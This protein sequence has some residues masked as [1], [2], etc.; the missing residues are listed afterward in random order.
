MIKKIKSSLFIKVFLLTTTLLIVVSLLVFGI[1]AVVTPN[2]YSAALND[3]LDVKVNAFTSEL[4]KVTLDTSKNLFEQFVRGTEIVNVEL[5]DANGVLVTSP[6]AQGGATEN[7]DFLA[8][9]TGV[10]IAS[11]NGDSPLVSNSYYFSFAGSSDRYLLVVYTSA[12]QVSQL[13]QT[14]LQIF[15]FLLLA[16][17]LISFAMSSIFSRIITKPVLKISAISQ[18]MSNLELEWD[19]EETRTDELGVLEKRLCELSYNLKTALFELKTANKQLEKDIALEK[20]LEKARS[21]FFSAVSHE[22]KT[23]ITVI[24]GQLEGMILN[25]GNYKDREKYLSRSLEVANVLEKMVGEIVTISRLESTTEA[26]SAEPF[27]IALAI[28]EY[29]TSTED[30]IVQKE[31]V[32]KTD[33]P[34]DIIFSGNRLLIEK[35][36]SNLIGNAIK[37]APSGAKIEIS[38]TQVGAKWQFAIMN[39]GTNIPIEAIPCLFEAFYRVDKSRS[40]KTGGSGLGL[41]LV[42]KILKQYGGECSVQNTSDGVTFSFTL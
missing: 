17:I 14:F 22:L 3:A 19:I 38:G 10:A 24:K 23:P 29:L 41:Y 15:P 4:E 37:Y 32:V 42:Q 25:V 27:N 35:V 39:T 20:A 11:E 2:T 40:R 1:L 33:L 31:L 21:D 12:S 8:E 7:T 34:K 28:R 16:I 9:G 13:E 30:I 5:Y 6:T 26:F 36:F 18:Q